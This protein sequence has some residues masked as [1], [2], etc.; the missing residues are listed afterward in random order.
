MTD[1]RT[2][3]L[4]LATFLGTVPGGLFWLAVV[5]GWVDPMLASRIMAVCVF[6]GLSGVVIAPWL[7]TG[8]DRSTRDRIADLLFV[9]TAGSA[10]A[11]LS[12]ELPF[13]LLSP[14]LVGVTA[15]DTWAWLWWAYG[16][17]DSRYLIADPFTV[18]MEGFTGL[19][20]GPIEIYALWLV[21]QGQLRKA[22]VCGVFLGFTQ[23]Y[24]AVLYFGIELFTGLAHINTANPIDLWIKFV[25][26]NAFW[27][28]L[29][30]VQA[31]ASVRVLTES[32]APAAASVPLNA[33]GRVRHEVA[34]PLET[35]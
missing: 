5:M 25:G 31:W 7:P 33:A 14:W 32:A 2:P 15:D 17:A 16:N 12:W 23:W 4:R 28:V 34:A 27:L 13:A 18:I 9:W 3:V 21:R 35:Q 1:L 22:A 24:G 6:I 29:P 8:D 11:Q 19:V 20:G 10:V 26:L 30:L